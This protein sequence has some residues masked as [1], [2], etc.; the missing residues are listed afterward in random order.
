MLRKH[1]KLTSVA[2]FSLSIAMAL[3][4]V[5]LSVGNTALLLPPAAPD[6]GSLVNIYSHA[7][8]DTDPVNQISWLDYQYFRANNHVFTGLAAAPNSI[9][10]NVDSDFD[11]QVVRVAS[12][13]VSANYFTVL[14][15]RPFLGR[16]FSADDDEHDNRVLVMT[17]TCWKRLGSNPHIVG[18]KLGEA[19]IIGVTPASFTGSFYGLNGDMLTA[20]G[21]DHVEGRDNWRTKRDD[22]R[23]ILLGRLKPGVTRA[24]A[25]N[26]IGALALQLASS[27]PNDDR[28]RRAVVTRATLLPPDTL[29]SAEIAT[30]ILIFLI[31]LLLLIAC[32]N[33]ATLLLA[34]AVGRR[35]EAAIKL[36]LGASR[37][38]LIRDFLRETAVICAFST[39]LGYGLALALIE[40]FSDVSLELPMFGEFSIG[41]NLH[42]DFTVVAFTLVLMCIAIFATGLSP[43]LYASSPRIA[44]ILSGELVVGGTRKTRLRNALAVAQVAICTLVLVGLGLCQRN[45]YNLRHSDPGFSARNLVGMMLSPQGEKL[46]EAHGKEFYS[47]L[48]KKIA[49]LPGVE[50]V[51]LAQS[52]PLFGSLPIPVQPP[53]GGK[54]LSI[55]SE[56]VDGAY[57]S[58]FGIA[59]QEGRAFNASDKEN[60]LPVILINRKMAE[61]YWPGQDALGKSLVIGDPGYRAT[62]IG[63]VADGKY[64]DLDEPRTP[65]LYLALSQHYLPQLYVVAR[66]H[67]DPAAVVAPVERAIHDL[68]MDLPLSPTT[69]ARWI[70]L[71]LLPQRL[72]AGIVAVLGALGLLLATMGLAGAISFAVSERRKELGIRV[73]LGAR[74]SQLLRM[75]LLQVTRVAGLGI[76]I[77][78]VLGVA[79]TVALQSQL[80]RIDPVEWRVLAPV[81]A[82][83]LA[84][85]LAVAYLAARPWLRADP[86]DAVRHQ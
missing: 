56:A 77:G 58:T 16:F 26:E 51:T 83:T 14:G 7:P 31:V 70:D 43:A 86:M 60:G 81:S 61:Q 65:F 38:R 25:Q 47:H 66:T 84:V 13:P 82:G 68:G 41:L 17:Y 55:G 80:Y 32:A 18:K 1:W 78:I 34:I 54:P 28:D 35:Q 42:L 21:A 63:I 48:Q 10:L 9:S 69:Y 67:G 11:H 79:A 49:T 19:T 50:A 37:W 75:I 71:T 22:R 5:A 40:R 53:G 72:V 30:G 36:A 85:L 33:V 39:V 8:S 64:G 44:Q 27:F 46:D 2:I 73:A 52:L 29:S 24:Q 59:L 74:S 20:L 76:A 57:F 45:L 4:V 6:A 15:I 23:F 12:R 3:G 62:V